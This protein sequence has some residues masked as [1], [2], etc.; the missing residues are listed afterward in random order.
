MTDQKPYELLIFDWDGTLMDSEAH[1]V[2]C[3]EKAMEVVALEPL[4]GAQ[5]RQV[6]GLGLEEAI[7]GIMP[8]ASSAVQQQAVT[9]FR[10]YFL[11][12]H[13]IPSKLFPGVEEVLEKLSNQGYA[14]AVATGKSRR[15]LDKVLQ[16]TGLGRYFPVSRCADE[17][18]SKP[19]PM[20]LEEILVDM[21]TAAD[22]ALMI[23]DTEFDL[24]MAA[25]AG[26]PAVGMSYGVHAVERLQ[27]ASPLEILHQISDLPEWLNGR[28]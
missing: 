25:N 1:I 20:M 27:S 4:P 21:D 28:D 5:L 12:P 2:E 9:A 14:M 13:P 7:S 26:V 6:I 23:G 3:L 16:Q 17:T 10:E 24:L 18:F 15:G 11:S 8:S 19:H 22:R